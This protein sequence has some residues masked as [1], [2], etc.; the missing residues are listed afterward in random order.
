MSHTF[1]HKTQT[2]EPQTAEPQTIATAKMVTTIVN[3]QRT[4]RDER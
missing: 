1:P 4:S 2:A 3:G